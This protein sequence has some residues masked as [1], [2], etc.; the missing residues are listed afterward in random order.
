M[1]IKK[2]DQDF[3]EYEVVD[4]DNGEIIRFI[5]S[6]DDTKGVYVVYDRDNDGYIKFDPKMNPV[7]KYKKGNIKIEKINKEE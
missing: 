5:V 2:T 7:M 1:N 3:M 6:A 4:L